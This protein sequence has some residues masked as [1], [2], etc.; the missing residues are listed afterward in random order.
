MEDKSVKERLEEHLAYASLGSTSNG[1]WSILFP[2]MRA[3]SNT[4]ELANIAGAYWLLDIIASWQTR[5]AVRTILE[6]KWT[7]TV[8]GRKFV[9][10][11]TD[12]DL[13]TELARQEG[14]TDFP[15]EH[16]VLTVTNF[17]GVRLIALDAEN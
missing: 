5:P 12:A 6:Q 4:L 15:L 14:D 17:N 7:L 8:T 16:L 1:R 11:C 10:V 13:G 3:T 2:Y 9:I